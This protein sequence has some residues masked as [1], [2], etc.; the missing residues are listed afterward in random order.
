MEEFTVTILRHCYD[1]FS[2]SGTGKSLQ[3]FFSTCLKTC[4]NYLLIIG[5]AIYIEFYILKI[6]FQKH[7]RKFQ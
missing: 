5:A 6:T 2:N 1:K 3:Q 4:L 7:I